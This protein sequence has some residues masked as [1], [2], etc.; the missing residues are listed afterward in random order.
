MSHVPDTSL[1]ACDRA[2]C[3]AWYDA[4][5]VG[6]QE[7]PAGWLADPTFGLHLCPAHRSTHTPAIKRDRTGACTC[8]E[9]LP[10]SYLGAIK[11]A[12]LRHLGEETVH[13]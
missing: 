9:P 13:A 2:D 8:G 6:G 12:Y 7:P 11:T 10:G 5:T 4:L 1:R 3:S